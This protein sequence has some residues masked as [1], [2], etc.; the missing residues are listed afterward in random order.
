MDNGKNVVKA[1]SV[2]K[3]SHCLSPEDTNH[4]FGQNSTVFAMYEKDTEATMPLSSLDLLTIVLP[5]T[6]EDSLIVGLGHDEEFL[7]E[8]IIAESSTPGSIPS[9]LNC[10]ADLD[11]YFPVDIDTMLLSHPSSQTK[12]ADEQTVVQVRTIDSQTQTFLPEE[13]TKAQQTV[14]FPETNVHNESEIYYQN[15][16]TDSAAGDISLEQRAFDVTM[17]TKPSHV[18]RNDLSS[19]SHVKSKVSNSLKFPPCVICNGKASGSHYGAITCEACKGFFRRY[20]QKK[21]EFKC[22]KGGKCE[23]SS[24]KKGNCSGCRLKKCLALGMSKGMSKLGRYTL[25]KR[26][27]AIINMKRLEGNEAH[28]SVTDESGVVVETGSDANSCN[29]ETH[30]IMRHLLQNTKTS[31]ISGGFNDMLVAELVQAMEDLEPYG[32]NV[33]TKEQINEQ[34]K[35]QAERYR[36]KTELFGKMNRIPKDE[37]NKLYKEF[38]IDIDGRMA[39]M[40]IEYEDIE[41]DTARYCNFA[42]HIPEFHNLPLLD[43]SN[44]LKALM[45]D[46]FTVVMVDAYND[47][48]RT[49]ISKNGHGYHF[50]EMADREYSAKLLTLFRGVCC[51]L[52]KLDLSKAETALL[53]ALTLVSTDRCKLQ[54]RALVEK[55]QLAITELLQQEIKKKHKQAARSRFTKIIDTLTYMREMSDVFTKENNVLCQDEVLIQEFPF[56]VDFI[57]EEN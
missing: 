7:F 40:K 6:P 36:L 31:K 23:I 57:I 34:H 53:G 56:L 16:C 39:D 20:L 42:K 4:D 2:L 26:T 28:D 27:E 37:Y 29:S 17:S 3:A 52:Q 41:D 30:V 55:I 45:A 12:Q 33:K 38:G 43:Q 9:I 51:R 5:P 44:L 22:T 25:A 46:F 18:L 1:C 24:G 19:K 13:V 11:L 32:P 21:K 54:N 48:L 50:D 35:H 15:E 10:R 14:S 47:E 8:D 49:I